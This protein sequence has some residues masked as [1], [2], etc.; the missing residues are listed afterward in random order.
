M[1]ENG[2]TDDFLCKEWFKHSFIPQATTQNAS[3]KPILLIYD[4]HGSHEKLELIRLARE[5]NIILFC[6]PPH[7]T[8][9][10]QPL[11]VGVFGPFQRA[12]SERCDEIVEDTGEEM[13]RED[14][15]KEYMGVRNKTFKSTTIISAF[16]KSGCWPINRDVFTDEDYAPSIPTSTTSCSVPSSF[17]VG[18]PDFESDDEYPAYPMEDPNNSE[19]DDDANDAINDD[20]NSQ[21]DTAILPGVPQPFS[22][23][24]TPVLSH[25]P[26]LAPPSVVPNSTTLPVRVPLVVLEPIPPSVF[27]AS[28]TQPKRKRG[29]PTLFVNPVQAQLDTLSQA[30]SGLSQQITELRSENSMLKAHCAIAG[31]EIQDLKRR[32]NTKENRHQKRRKLN[33]DARWLNSDEGL[34]LAEEQEALRAAEEQKKHEAREQ[35]VAKEAEREEQRRH[36]DPNAP[37]TGAL[38]SKT[39][40]DL[41]DIAQV[42]GL[43]T[44]GQK[45]DILAR[46]N[47]HFDANPILRDDSRFEGIFNRT[48]RRITMQTEDETLNAATTAASTGS[49][50]F[51]PLSLPPPPAPLSSNI[52]NTHTFLCTSFPSASNATIPISSPSHSHHNL[53]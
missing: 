28:T 27:Y 11:D 18:T 25:Y 26:P 5:H 9:K 32:L 50:S 44:D 3:G 45:K 49:S 42:L 16:R 22:A 47:A 17:P 21:T 40:A 29:R 10:L 34:R 43:A 7:T 13:P 39:R 6:L 12:W 15:V 38:T 48:R 35:R 1:S 30:Y 36:R 37:F 24:S 52:V 33:V 46:I 31:T 51:G 53:Y 4:G 20:E 14:F 23:E 41:Q 2:W 8:H 19:S